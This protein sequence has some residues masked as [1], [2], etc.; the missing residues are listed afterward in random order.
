M[1]VG[2]VHVDKFTVQPQCRVLTL[3]PTH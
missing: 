3:W 1:D 2:I